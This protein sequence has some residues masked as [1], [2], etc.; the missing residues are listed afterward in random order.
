MT[1]G[2]ATSRHVAMCRRSATNQP[3]SSQLWPC[4]TPRRRWGARGV[5]PPLWG[6][7]KRPTIC[8][9]LRYRVSRRLGDSGAPRSCFA[10]FF[11]VVSACLRRSAH[12]RGYIWDSTPSG[13]SAPVAQRVTRMSARDGASRV[14]SAGPSP[15]DPARLHGEHPVARV[16]AAV[17]GRL[18]AFAVLAG[19]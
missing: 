13:S 18:T 8:R 19:S 7:S 17:L 16:Y 15:A 4:R 9:P 12:V 1:L 6:S 10:A 2:Q 5:L 11:R 3:G 14:H